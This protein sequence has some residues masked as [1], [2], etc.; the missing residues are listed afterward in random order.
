MEKKKE[1]TPPGQTER[2]AHIKRVLEKTRS[3]LCTFPFHS[4]LLWEAFYS[5]YI[6]ENFLMLYNDVLVQFEIQFLTKIDVGIL[7]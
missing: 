2:L 4:T 6:F 3:L 5:L 1:R 7:I